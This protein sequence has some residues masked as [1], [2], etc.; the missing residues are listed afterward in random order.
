MKT[1][2]R[3]ALVALLAAVI[4][5]ACLGCAYA[6]ATANDS[7][8]ADIISRE[9]AWDE[10]RSLSL[11][12]RSVVRYVQT[13]G[14]GRVIARG[15]HRSVST[16]L[17]SGGEIR[18]Q[19]LHTGATL[20]IT[21]FAPSISSFH[22]GAGSKL[23]LEEYNQKTLALSTE[24]A[25][26]VEGAGRAD[27]VSIEMRGSGVVNLSRFATGTATADLGGM[28]TLVVAPSETANL[29][30]R[31]FASAVLLTRPT[32]LHTTLTDSGRIIDAAPH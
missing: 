32:G 9:M 23:R 15:P 2:T 27:E 21:I 26:V 24:G 22:L 10:S 29:T 17:V 13:D 11:G 30:V 4:S 1:N 12:V 5:A 25:A 28:S 19:L 16:L 14:P 20:D 8:S 31:N 3:L 7:G 18:D 6:R